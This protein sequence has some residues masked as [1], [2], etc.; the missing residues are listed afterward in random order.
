LSNLMRILLIGLNYLPESTSIGPYTADLAEYMQARGHRVR[1]VTGFPMAPQ[2][3]VW[4]GYRGRLFQ[5][6]TINGVPVLRTWLYVPQHPRSALQRILFD[7]SFALTAFVGGIFSGACDLVVVISPPLQ[8]GL[9]GWLLGRLKHAPCF[10]HLQDLVPDAAIATGMLRENS[11]GALLARQIE[12]F[13]YAH[14][15]GVGVICD[16]FARNLI[17]KGVPPD[18]IAILPDY[19]DLDWMQPHARENGFR[20]QHAI[21]PNQFV[22]LYSGSVALKQ[23]LNT[24][25]EAA[26]ELRERSD[27]LFLLIGEGPY[28]S[29]LRARAKALALPNLRCLP[30]QPRAQ[31]PQQL[32][33]ADALVITQKRTITDVV[34]PGK[35][36]YY[37]A[38]ARPI[39]A[40]VSENS[41]TGR[42]IRAQQ[43]GVVIPPEDPR[44]LAQ[45]II[46][47]REQGSR[48]MGENG[49]RVA[50]TQF[51]RRV[52]LRRFAEHLESL[53]KPIVINDAAIPDAPVTRRFTYRVVKRFVD[54]LGAGLGLVI[55]SP[56]FVLIAALVKLTSAGPI[57]YN[58]D[59]LGRGAK[60]FRGYKFRTM[61]ANADALKP[62]LRAYNQMRGPVFK[63]EH[64]PRVTPF[65]RVLR[66]YSLDELPQLWS[67][68]R[69]DMSLVGPRP[70]GREEWLG[71]KLWQQRKLSVT[72]GITCLWQV[73]GRNRIN[74]FD[75]WVKLDLEYIDHWSLWLDFKILLR[76]IAVVLA[77]TGK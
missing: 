41:E 4:D 48:G 52:V 72:P 34:F 22:V 45:A 1:V 6:E 29:E 7:I 20:Q 26:A 40:A 27:I 77:G 51:D 10:I 15:R 3:R 43:V 65:G 64:D 33:A 58:W 38:A 71:Y 57:F 12:K 46:E 68:L 19:V 42:F 37:M 36:L 61:A 8:L 14:A 75:E 31:L 76:T 13:V 56:L 44:G 9:S 69:G 24:F 49:R 11:V 35:L 53:Q 63:M 32:S 23:G 18:K 62:Q 17:A 67:V 39:L 21:S 28:L 16:G 50:E 30:L 60:P 73:N 74:D 25:V 47:L 5:R 2:W 59:V 70:A 54:V 66:Q 55:L